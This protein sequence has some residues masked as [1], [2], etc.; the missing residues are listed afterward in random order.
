MKLI[1]HGHHS[2]QNGNL[3]RD[4]SNI[5]TAKQIAERIILTV[6]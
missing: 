3:Y 2:G 6:N 1:G 4:M 5:T